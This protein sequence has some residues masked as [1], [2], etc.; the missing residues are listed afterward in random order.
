ML[1]L[2][3]S[4]K[5]FSCDCNLNVAVVC[6]GPE[7][8]IEGSTGGRFRVFEDDNDDIDDDDDEDDEGHDAIDDLVDEIE[9]LDEHFFERGTFF[10]GDDAD[11]RWKERGGEPSDIDHDLI[12]RLETFE[13]KGI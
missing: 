2:F 11:R 13:M 8:N 6:L 3:L 10:G 1:A 7:P 4:N 12:T 9:E 5:L